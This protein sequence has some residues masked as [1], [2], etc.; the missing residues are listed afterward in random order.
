MNSI[1]E[2]MLSI[3]PTFSDMEETSSSILSEIA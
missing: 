1:I 2:Q 3:L